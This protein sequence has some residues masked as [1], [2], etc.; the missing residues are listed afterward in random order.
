MKE[1]WKD[2]PNYEGYYQVSDLGNIK[3][4]KRSGKVLSKIVANN[5]YLRVHLSKD[6]TKKVWGIHQLVAMAFLGHKPNGHKIIVDHIDGDR[7][8]NNLYNLQVITQRENATRGVKNHY[9]K[10]VGVCWHKA[11]NKW[12]SRIQINRKT[13]SLGYFDCEVKASEAYQDALSK[14]K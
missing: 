10:Y 9:S 6:A 4:L 14:I 11:T 13:V 1:E 5:G 12:T 3:S 2:I 8:N 7:T